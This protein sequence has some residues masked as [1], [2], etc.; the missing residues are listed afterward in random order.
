MTPK[1]LHAIQ[2]ALHESGGNGGVLYGYVVGDRVQIGERG[3]RP[4]YFSHFFRRVRAC[5]CVTVLPS[6]I[7]LSPRAMPSR[8]ATRACNCS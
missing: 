5:A 4:D 1:L 2:R 6:A 3:L 7:A 8:M